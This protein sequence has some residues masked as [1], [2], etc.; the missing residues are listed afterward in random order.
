M[1]HVEVVAM[2]T[3]FINLT[4]HALVIRLGDR[5]IVVPA[6]GQQ[7]RVASR[8]I[9]A[10]T[11]TE[12]GG[13]EVPL[14]RNEYGNVEGL[15]EPQTDTI[16]LV[17]AMVLGRVKGRQDVAAPDTGPTAIRDGGQVKAVVRLVLA[18]A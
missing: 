4:P 12:V 6:S 14:F 8:A 16:Y 11:V 9:S 7:A 13:L 3:K 2:T 18:D 5:D 1:L 17:S 15:P 10:G